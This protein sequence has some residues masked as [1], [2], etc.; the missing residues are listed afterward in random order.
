MQPFHGQ[1]ELF[2]SDHQDVINIE[3]VIG[4]C[5]VMDLQNY[6]SQ[7]AQPGDTDFFTRFHYD[8]SRHH[9]RQCSNKHK[10][11]SH[12]LLAEREHI[13]ALANLSSFDN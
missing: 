13:E 11:P 4:K 3:A 8:V 5:R 6:M 1:H 7:A 9:N 2:S 12:S 10:P